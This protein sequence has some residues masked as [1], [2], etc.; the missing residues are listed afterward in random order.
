MKQVYLVGGIM[1]VGKTTVCQKAKLLLHNSV[2]LDGDWCWDA[3]PFQITEETKHMVMDNI[4]YLLNNFIHCSAYENIIFCWVMHEQQIIDDLVSRLDLQNCD[5]KTI[6]L[7]CTEQT[8]RSHLQKDIDT[9]VRSE[10]II[11][12]SVQRIKLYDSLDTIKISIDNKSPDEVAV[13]IIGEAIRP[14]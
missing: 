11:K 7:T 5:L 4:S 13:E 14:K 3:N 9:G 12:R 2:L 6:S 10:D 8:L 1:G